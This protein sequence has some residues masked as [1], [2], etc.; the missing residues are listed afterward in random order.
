MEAFFFPDFFLIWGKKCVRWRKK[1]IKKRKNR[2][3]KIIKKLYVWI[4]I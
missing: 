2:K 4:F 1:K 3:K